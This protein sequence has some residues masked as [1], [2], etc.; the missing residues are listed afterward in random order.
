M[1]VDSDG[2]VVP[3]GDG[4]GE[5]EISVAPILAGLGLNAVLVYTEQLPV[6]LRFACLDLLRR[7][8]FDPLDFT[9]ATLQCGFNYCFGAGVERVDRCLRS[10]AFNVKSNTWFSS[11]AS[12]THARET[13]RAKLFCAQSG[14]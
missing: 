2:P 8:Q 6:I 1:R 4:L 9:D 3:I 7:R 10:E 11:W 13:I 5:A 14:F 12:G